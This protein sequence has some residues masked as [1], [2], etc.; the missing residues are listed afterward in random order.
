[1]TDQLQLV[2]TRFRAMVAIALTAGLALWIIRGWFVPH[3]VERWTLGDIVASLSNGAV[4]LVSISLVCS[5]VFAG[6]RFDEKI[7]MVAFF[8]GGVL[9]PLG[10]LFPAVYGILHCARFVF[11]MAAFFAACHILLSFR[12]QHRE[13]EGNPPR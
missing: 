11:M 13:E 2:T 4:F 9:I 10:R 6:L 3:P 5:A 7:L 8:A 12:D 1:M